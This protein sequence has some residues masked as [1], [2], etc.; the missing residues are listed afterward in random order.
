MGGYSQRGKNDQRHKRY[1]QQ[2][3]LLQ[4]RKLLKKSW[5]RLSGRQGCCALM[6]GLAAVGAVWLE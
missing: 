1:H 4:D 2:A 3:C 5:I 6:H